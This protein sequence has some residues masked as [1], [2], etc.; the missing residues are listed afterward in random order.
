MCTKWDYADRLAPLDLLRCAAAFKESIY[1]NPSSVGREAV[2]N[3]GPN[4]K[5][6]DNLAMM[7]F[8]TMANQFLTISG[9]SLMITP[10]QVP[11]VLKFLESFTD[12]FNRN[13][14]VALTTVAINYAVVVQQTPGVTLRGAEERLLKAMTVVLTN[15]RDA[16][17]LFRALVAVGTIL[18]NLG[19]VHPDEKGT[20]D[21][22][23]LEKAIKVA[24]DRAS[25]SRVKDVADECLALL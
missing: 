25:E 7:T 23:D 2:L 1:Y 5:P 10:P 9:R 20:L 24:K 17:V 8:R 3:I 22:V 15:Q 4:D 14:Q 18:I 11:E 19:K 6:N 21:K 16:E 13:L 12:S